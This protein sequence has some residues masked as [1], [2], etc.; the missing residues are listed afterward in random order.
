MKE[1]A[2]KMAPTRA[3]LWEFRRVG[4]ARGWRASSLVRS[5]LLAREFALRGNV[6]CGQML[7]PPRT[8]RKKCLPWKM[9]MEVGFAIAFFVLY[10]GI[11]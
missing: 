2:I 10:F 1:Q 8:R 11:H 9:M 7:V 6:F 5:W 4:F 3:W